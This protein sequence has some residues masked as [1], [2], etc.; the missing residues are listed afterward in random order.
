[1]P[2]AS[3]RRCARHLYSNFRQ[4]FPGLKLKVNFWK[5]VKSPNQWDWNEAMGEIKKENILAY[6]WLMEKPLHLW[7][8]HAFDVDVKSDHVTNNM[9]E[10]FNQWIGTVRGKPVLTLLENI[11]IKLMKRFHDRYVQGYT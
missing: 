6:N 7:T 4:Q 10:S 3:Q 9:T 1:M 5:A 2:H 8:R 11:R